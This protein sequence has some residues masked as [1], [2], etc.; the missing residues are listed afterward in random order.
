MPGGSDPQRPGQND[1]PTIPSMP[2][3]SPNGQSRRRFLRNAVVASA[4]SAAAVGAG[5]ALIGATPLGPKLMSR[6]AVVG[7]VVSPGCIPL[8]EGS[9][10]SPNSPNQTLQ[11]DIAN[12][13]FFGT[14]SG[15][16]VGSTLTLSHTPF[17]IT[18]TAKS[19]GAPVLTTVVTG[20][21]VANGNVLK[22]FI[23]PGVTGEYPTG[24]CIT[25]L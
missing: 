17:N 25:I 19:G 22:L 23:N 14:L 4:A 11:V 15:T 12:A 3:V 24:S 1:E 6:V 2:S 13:S 10:G 20:G 7:A 5:A 21:E 16:A 8:K 18:L 9:K